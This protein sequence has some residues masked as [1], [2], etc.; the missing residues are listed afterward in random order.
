V[1]VE[2]IDARFA[3]PLDADMLARVLVPGRP[4][5]TVEDHHAINGFGAAVT[6]HAVAA[7]LPTESLTILGMPDR[8]IPHMTRA[9]QLEEASLHPQGIAARVME[10]LADRGAPQERVIPTTSMAASLPSR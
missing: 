1:Q 10:R 8:L 4:V 6:E 5:L 7:G 2:V 3:K 9:Q